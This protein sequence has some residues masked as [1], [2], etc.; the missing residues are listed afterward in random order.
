MVDENY[1]LS[2]RVAEIAEKYGTSVAAISIA[3]LTN[4]KINVIPIM[5]FDNAKQIKDAIDGA[6]IILTKEDMSS[7]TL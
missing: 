3:Y 6:N 1:T 7:L 5:F 2:E 4:Q